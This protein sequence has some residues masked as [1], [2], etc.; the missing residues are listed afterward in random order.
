MERLEPV[1]IS[2]SKSWS[3]TDQKVNVIATTNLADGMVYRFRH[4]GLTLGD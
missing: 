2:L 1:F 3:G 4:P